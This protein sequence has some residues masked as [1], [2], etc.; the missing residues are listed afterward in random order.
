MM[1][2][3]SQREED[4]HFQK[5]KKRNEAREWLADRFSDWYIKFTRYGGS[6]VGMPASE[7]MMDIG[8]IIEAAIR[9]RWR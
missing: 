6:N 9:G 8:E 7:S 1:E 5:E 3:D 2:R 4:K